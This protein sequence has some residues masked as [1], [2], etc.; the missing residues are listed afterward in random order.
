MLKQSSSDIPVPSA[1]IN[2]S[3]TAP[4]CEHY[5]EEPNDLSGV[6]HRMSHDE[7]LPPLGRSAEMLDLSKDI[8]VCIF[9]SKFIKEIFNAFLSVVSNF[10]VYGLFFWAL[11]NLMFDL[12]FCIQQ[13]LQVII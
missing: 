12:I 1:P 9:S 3:K 11:A 13:Q 7:V 2:R 5:F 6:Q 10:V 4:V 8:D